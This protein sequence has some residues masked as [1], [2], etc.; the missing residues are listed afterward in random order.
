MS[1]LGYNP[2]EFET[3]WK[4]KWLKTKLNKTSKKNKE[5]FYSLYSFPYPSGSG[6]HVGHVEGM[7]ANDIVARFYKM[8]GR[9]VMLPMGWD[10]FGLPAENYAIKTG[11]HPSEST[12]SAISTFIEQI[13]NV[14]IS[15]DWSKEVA[16]HRPD[17]YRWTQ[18]I[19]LQLFKKG[20]AY[21]KSAPV[22]WCPKDQTVLANEQVINGKCER[23]DTEV[24]Q[25]DL[26]QWFF[27][28]TDFS[29][30]LYKD[31]DTVDWPESTKAMQRNW[32]G[33]SVGAEIIWRL[34][35]PETKEEF[36]IH[37]FTTRFDTIPGPTFMVIAPEYPDIGKFI[38]KEYKEQ[39]QKY[40]ESVKNRTNLERQSNKEKTGVFT[41]SYAINPYNNEKVPIYIADYVLI[42][43]GTGAVMGMPGHDQ[44]DYEFAKR[45]NLPIKYTLKPNEKDFEFPNNKAFEEE[46]YEINSG[47]FDGL[48][49]KD[50]REKIITKLENEGNAIRRTNYKL[51]DWLVSRQRYWGCPIPI[52]YCDKCKS[53]GKGYS[54]EM[55]GIYPVDD[56]LNNEVDFSDIKKVLV[57]HGTKGTSQSNWL[58]WLK[59]ELE[60]KNIEV[61]IPDLPE[62]LNYEKR[63]NFLKEKYA[64]FL[65]EDTIIIGHSSGATAALHIANR[66]K[67]KKLILVAPVLYMDEDYNNSFTHIADK[68]TAD[69]LAEYANHNID[70][71]RI[72]ENAQDIVM[73]FGEQDTY[74]PSAEFLQYSHKNYPTAATYVFEDK[75]HFSTTTDNLKVFPDLLKYLDCNKDKLPV[76]LPKDV[77]FRPTGESPLTRSASF[78]KNV[79]CPKCGSPAYR[80]VDT[81]DT[82]VDSSWYFFRFC[83]ALNINEFAKGENMN[84]WLPTDLYM[85][86]AEHIVLHLLY[87][88]FFTKFFYDQG[89]ISFNEPFYKMRHMGLILGP[90]GRK[91]S[92]RWGNVINPDDEVKKYGGD[93]VRM[94]EMFMGPI[95][96][97]KPWNDTA[98]T[99]ISRF[100][101]RIWN[102][103]AKV[104]NS[105]VLDKEIHNKQ[106]ILIN[107]LIKKVEEDIKN[108]SFN[109]SVAKFME[110][111]NEVSKHEKISK[112]VWEKFLL[113]LA[114]FAPFIT[115]ELWER[116]GNKYSIHQESWPL[117]NENV[118][119][120]DSI[121][122]TIQ[123]N[124]KVRSTMELP[125]NSDEETVR[126]KAVSF[127]NVKKYLITDPKK[128]IYI[129]NKVINFII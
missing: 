92:K 115:E 63:M 62:E 15:V 45:Y 116:M 61:A 17:Y 76:I 100:L 33:K 104:L 19:F 81:M 73:L 121:V 57:L 21:R 51:R 119:V 70:P 23:C 49:W 37:T 60:K 55:P 85:I 120:N 16:A 122:I 47:E 111:S 11:V 99:G 34:D 109:T 44:R 48:W 96:D 14:G 40:I 114:P 113:T 80:E 89:Y 26:K 38:T 43:Y 4:K 107:K 25:K 129:K 112:N 71:L 50:A 32:I 22:N 5:K 3:K 54:K 105:E 56:S 36:K 30:R 123:I 12:E 2:S 87:S 90:D 31:L 64:E 39:T 10:S 125:I 110:F 118:L 59:S 35:N 46:G 67:I 128:I 101:S 98:E 78:N 52:I 58:P 82:F 74:T 68:Q 28:I 41:G 117:F 91:M 97:S 1:S 88:R 6:L 18:W 79:K 72:M 20:L 13:N 27:K 8:Q 126:L 66:Y 106:E 86:G 108:L 127:D 9:D 77:D 24:I 103:Q 7:V 65:T 102:L 124:G 42:N 53:E 84:E 75:K 95:E 29:E 69:S 93:T 83:D 94:Y